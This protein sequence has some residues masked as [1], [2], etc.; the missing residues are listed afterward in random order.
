MPGIINT[1]Y[2]LK[3]KTKYNSNNRQNNDATGEPATPRVRG[4]RVS[5]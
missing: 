4:T 3:N 2:N 1:G 5:K